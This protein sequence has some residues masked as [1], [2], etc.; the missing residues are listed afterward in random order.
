MSDNCEKK[1]KRLKT[2]QNQNIF[3]LQ[4]YKTEKCNAMLYKT[5]SHIR[6]AETSDFA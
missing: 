1:K 4:S 5:H 6:V 2:V 3:N